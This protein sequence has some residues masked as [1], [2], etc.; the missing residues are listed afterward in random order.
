MAVNYDDHH[1]HSHYLIIRSGLPGFSPREVA[2]LAQM[3][4]YHRKGDPS[5]DDLAPLAR[6]GDEAMLER[7]AT[8]LRVVEQLERA[9]DGRVRDIA[10]HAHDGVVELE[11]DT[12]A[13]VSFAR[14]AAERQAPLFEQAFGRSLVLG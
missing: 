13:D 12:T 3:A 8:V 11:L 5:L 4:R 7:C 2:L 1:K 6:E 10:V 9:R 14:W